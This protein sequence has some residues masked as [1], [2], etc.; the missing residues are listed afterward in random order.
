MTS[1]EQEVLMQRLPRASSSLALAGACL[2]SVLVLAGPAPA[3]PVPS[4]VLKR[5]FALA[6]QLPDRVSNTPT[7]APAP[8]S[9]R[10]ES[11]GDQTVALVLASVALAVA[12]GSGL[13]VVVRT[14]RVSLT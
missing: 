10:V 14:H 8:A 1:P 2:L 9:T 5:E 6:H 12:L 7:I 13:V 4:A 3:K 11:R